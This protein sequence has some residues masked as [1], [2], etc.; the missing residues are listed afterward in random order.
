[1]KKCSGDIQ[2]NSGERCVL[3]IYDEDDKIFCANE[4]NCG[5]FGRYPTKSRD[6]NSE[7][8]TMSCSGDGTWANKQEGK[9]F[10]E[11]V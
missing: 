11:Y 3:W 9:Y 6:F 5:G 10:H 8:F 4:S 2:C 1:M 7:V